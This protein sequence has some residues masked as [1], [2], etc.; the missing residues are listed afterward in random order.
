MISCTVQDIK[1]SS[2]GFTIDH[3]Y[4]LGVK[5]DQEIP[6][7]NEKYITQFLIKPKRIYIKIK[8]NKKIKLYYLHI[9]ISDHEFSLV[10]YKFEIGKKI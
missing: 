1:Y 4:I 7:Y 2:F 10:K 9:Y 3:Y 6:F 5:T 8:E